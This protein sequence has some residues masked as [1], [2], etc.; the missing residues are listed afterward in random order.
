M[1]IFQP[2]IPG[3]LSGKLGLLNTVAQKIVVIFWL[4]L[5]ANDKSRRFISVIKNTYTT[6][7]YPRSHLYGTNTRIHS[8]ADS[9]LHTE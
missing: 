1:G 3:E 4:I 8:G 6:L 9:S 2:G 7:K 5:W